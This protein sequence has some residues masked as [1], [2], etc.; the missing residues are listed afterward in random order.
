VARQI[1]HNSSAGKDLM[2]GAISAINLGMK[3]S[4]PKPNLKNRM[5]ML[6]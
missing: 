3:L 1:I 5:Q 2:Q 6:K 4:F